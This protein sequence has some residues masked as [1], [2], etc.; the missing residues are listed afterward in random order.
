MAT[1]EFK[2]VTADDIETIV[3][4]D[5]ELFPENNF[6]ERTLGNQIMA[7]GGQLLL[8]DGYPAGYAV[9]SNPLAAL[10]DILR[11]GVRESY[12]CCGIGT[13]LLDNVL[14]LGKDTM[15]TVSKNNTPAINLYRK[16]QF[17]IVGVMP[18]HDSWV[19]VRSTRTSSW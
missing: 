13:V 18:Q 1:Y 6:N 4:L 3:A 11:L 12:R 7:G 14:R 19:M 17:E 8:V 5:F 9:I 16:H 10:V 15:L 2:Q